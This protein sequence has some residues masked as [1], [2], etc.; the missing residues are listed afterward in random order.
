MTGLQATLAKFCPTAKF[1]HIDI[2]PSQISKNVVADIPIVGQTAQ[3]LQA[4]INELKDKELSDI[5]KWWSQIE[6]WRKV[7][8]LAYKKSPG[9]IKPQSVIEAL[10]EVTEG[11]AIVTSDVGQHQMWAAQYYLLM[12]QGNGLILVVL[13]RWVLVFQLLWALNLQCQKKT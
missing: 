3:V 2:D 12:S 7:D 11:K 8:S 1:I 9:V 13:E 4:L 10:Y 5:S 6:E